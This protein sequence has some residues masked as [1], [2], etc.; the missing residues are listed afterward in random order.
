M[1]QLGQS[2]GDLI[3]QAID[4]GPRWLCQKYV[5]RQAG[6]SEKHLSQIVRG[7]VRMSARVAVQLEGP[8]GVPALDLLVAQ[9]LVDI[10]AARADRLRDLELD[11]T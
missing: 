10:A 1:T 8:L 3:R 2:P 9:A 7:A 4:N 5:A 6:I 11:E